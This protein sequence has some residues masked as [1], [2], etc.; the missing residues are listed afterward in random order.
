MI[1]THHKAA[2]PCLFCTGPRPLISRLLRDPYCSTKCDIAD[3]IRISECALQRL[4]EFKPA[5]AIPIQPVLAQ[6]VI[7]LEAEPT[8]LPNDEHWRESYSPLPFE[9]Q[10]NIAGG[11]HEAAAVVV[12]RRRRPAPASRLGPPER[13]Q[14]RV[15]PRRRRAWYAQ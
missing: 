4:M 8:W 13:S 3:S 9:G 10:E 11:T 12:L 5:P 1:F 15:V 7:G 14:P 2:A 6:P